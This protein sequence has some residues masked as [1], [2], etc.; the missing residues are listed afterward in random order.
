V[1]RDSFVHIII[2]ECRN[3]YYC[4][5]AWFVFYVCIYLGSLQIGTMWL[6]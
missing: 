3:N 6:L 4:Y 5:C 2:T 1:Y